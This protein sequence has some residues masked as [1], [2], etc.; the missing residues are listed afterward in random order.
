MRDEAA[1]WALILLALASANLPFCSER[2]MAVLP[3]RRPKSFR[4]RMLELL[5]WGVLTLVLG[6]LIE[7]WIGQ[8]QPQGW[9]FYAAFAFLFVTL[10]FPGFVWRQLRRPRRDTRIEPS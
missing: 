10:A 3:L 2:L 8:H 6:M 7:L 5:L 1:S 9:E 4:F